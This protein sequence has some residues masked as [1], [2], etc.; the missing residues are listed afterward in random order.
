MFKAMLMFIMLVGTL[1]ARKEWALPFS[2]PFLFPIVTYYAG[3]W[4]N[5]YPTIT[6]IFMTVPLL[7]IVCGLDGDNP[8]AQQAQA[9]TEQKSFR[10]VTFVWMP[11][12]FGFLVWC[13]WAFATFPIGLLDRLAFII[14]VGLNCGALGINI[15]HE[16]IHR[17]EINEQ[18]LGKC[19]L[20]MVCYGHW[21]IEHLRGHHKHVSTPNDPATAR[22][23]QTFYQ[24]WWQSVKGTWWSAWDLEKVRLAKQGEGVWS[25][26]NEI[27][28][29]CAGSALCAA[30]SYAVF[31]TLG[32]IMFLGQSFIAFSILELVNYI[33]H[34]GLARRPLLVTDKTG[35]VRYEAVNVI[36][37]WNADSKITNLFLFKLQRHSDHHAYASRRYQILRTFEN[38]PQMPT[39]YA[40]MITMAL[41][42]P[43]WFYVMN[44]RVE[45]FQRVSQAEELKSESPD[46]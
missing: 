16:L 43:L 31:G 24:F 21:Y 9:L 13:C 3:S 42:P 5:F 29:L 17:S 1:V 19:L 27:L 15:S 30:A 18:R 11:F 7:E 14:S 45:A 4:G 25:V 28:A 44:P 10:W 20:M 36:H 6:L 12:Q 40:G 38:S 2:L 35:K 41:I 34:Y 23:G 33:E 37:S 22:C 32:L 26:H 46:D 8:N 39:G